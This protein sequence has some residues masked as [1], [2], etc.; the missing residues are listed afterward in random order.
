[1]AGEPRAAVG[2]LAE[3]P[4]APRTV[5]GELDQ[6]AGLRVGRLDDVGGEVHRRGTLATRRLAMSPALGD[7]LLS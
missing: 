5:A 6:R 7:P 2:D 3:G 4:F 1:M